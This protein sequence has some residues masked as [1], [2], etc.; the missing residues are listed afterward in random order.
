MIKSKN[1]KVKCDANSF[2]CNAVTFHVFLTSLRQG[3]NF[4]AKQAEQDISR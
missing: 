1:I 3:Q 4:K 2:G